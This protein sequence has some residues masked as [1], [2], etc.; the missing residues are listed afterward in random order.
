MTIKSKKMNTRFGG[1]LPIVVDVE[2]AGLRPR[3]DALLEVACVFLEID[4]QGLLKPAKT[5]AY[6]VLPF[7][8]A[9]LDEKALEINQILDPYH[10][11][12]FAKEEE[13]VLK[14]LFKTINQSLKEENCRRAVLVGHNASFDLSFI[15]EASRRCKL[16]SPFHRFTC[17]DTATLAGITLG[18]TVLAKA[19]YAA[20]ISFDVKEAH[21]A[22]YDAEKTTELFCKIVNGHLNT[23]S[24]T[25]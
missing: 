19:L 5:E 15:Q 18:Q 3:T 4:N 23:I 17:F 7:K 9:N 21:S 1:Y 14:S 13:V 20:N 11:F 2:T 10:P 22:I 16:R 25:Q 8:G 6:H 24:E 12:R